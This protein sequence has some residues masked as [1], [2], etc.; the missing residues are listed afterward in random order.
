MIGDPKLGSFSGQWSAQTA[1]VPGHSMTKTL[2]IHPQP[3]CGQDSLQLERHFRTGINAYTLIST[4]II[5]PTV[6]IIYIAVP[7]L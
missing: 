2:N 5:Q 4:N 3:Y 6:Y 7:Q 1:K